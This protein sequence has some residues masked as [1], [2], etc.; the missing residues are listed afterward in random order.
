[1]VLGVNV[2]H[3]HVATGEMLLQLV[4][5]AVTVPTF[6]IGCIWALW[7]YLHLFYIGSL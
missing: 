5:D 7:H 3:A 1:M 2:V 4:S 6:M